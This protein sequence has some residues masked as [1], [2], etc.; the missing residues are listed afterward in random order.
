MACMDSV[1]DRLEALRDDLGCDHRGVF[2]TTYLELSRELR[3]AFDEDPPFFQDS[4]Y[5]QTQAVTF[6]DA[7]L[8]AFEAWETGGEVAPAWRPGAR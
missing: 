7:Y 4:A 6:V 3:R 8:D 5:L 1:V 2:A